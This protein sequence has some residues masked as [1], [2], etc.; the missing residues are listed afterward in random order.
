MKKDKDL[1]SGSLGWFVLI[2]III[3]S[4][5]VGMLYYQNN[6]A[7]PN[8]MKQN[9]DFCVKICS[10]VFDNELRYCQVTCEKLIREL[11]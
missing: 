2:I 11:R 3:V 1:V 9:Y 7:K 10:T 4:M 8:T 6:I 5:L